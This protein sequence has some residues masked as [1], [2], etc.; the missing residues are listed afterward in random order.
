MQKFKKTQVSKEKQED[1]NIKDLSAKEISVYNVWARKYKR[2]K[3]R[4]LQKEKALR[5]FNSKIARTINIRHLDLIIN[6]ADP[7]S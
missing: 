6:C 5:S 3:A 2:N 4:Q 7:Y 1:I